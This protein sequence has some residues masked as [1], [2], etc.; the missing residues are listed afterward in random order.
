MILVSPLLKLGKAQAAWTNKL[1]CNSPIVGYLGIVTSFFILVT[2][3]ACTLISWG[4][5]LLSVLDMENMDTE[6][7]GFAIIISVF[8]I[9]GLV[10]LLALITQIGSIREHWS[11]ISKSKSS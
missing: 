2:M 4:L 11:I 8:G 3:A 7:Q 5:V 1:Y 10:A 9:I 6:S